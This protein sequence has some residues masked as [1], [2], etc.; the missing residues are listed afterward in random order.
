[1]VK[2]TNL[3]YEQFLDEVNQGNLLMGIEPA[4]ARRFYTDLTNSQ[5]LEKSGRS[6]SKRSTIVKLFLGLEM[7][8]LITSSISAIYALNWW[9]LAF[10]PSLILLWTHWK[11]SSSMGKPKFGGAIFLFL[12][13]ISVAIY[14]SNLGTSYIIMF[15]T[16]T[17]PNIFTKLV[18][19]FSAEFMRDLVKNSE[20]AFDYLFNNKAVF[21]LEPETGRIIKNRE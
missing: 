16:A 9:S 10:I 6:Q 1:M 21:F 20:K 8:A 15:A 11:S 13:G 14:F 19:H 17:L 5:R 2:K 7:L 18:Y 12:C 3:D 4:L